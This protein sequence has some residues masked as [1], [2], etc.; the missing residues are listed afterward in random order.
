[1]L[2]AEEDAA[3][4]DRL[5]A[6]PVVDVDLLDGADGAADAGVVE[7]DVELAELAHGA[8]DQGLDV[9]L[10]GDVGALEDRAGAAGGGLGGDG[11]AALGVEVGQD[12]IGALAA[13]RIAAAWPMPLA[14]PV[15]TATLP[16]R[17]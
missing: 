16:V 13:N 4:A 3:Q 1:V 6:V 5:G 2:D 17:S 10:V 8:G 14:A 7:Q 15:M 11:L 12:D 9:G